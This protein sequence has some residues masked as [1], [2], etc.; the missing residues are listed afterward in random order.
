MPTKN[1]KSKFRFET[2]GAIA[3][4]ALVGLSSTADA[5]G[6][7]RGTQTATTPRATVTARAPKLNTKAFAPK[8]VSASL[9]SSLRGKKLMVTPAHKTSEYTK[10]MQNS[11]E[12]IYMPNF[13]STGHTLIRVGDRLFDHVGPARNQSFKEVMATVRSPAYGFVFSRTTGQVAQLKA[14]FEAMAN[15]GHG[16]SYTGSGPTTFSCAGFITHVLK[17]HAPELE[18]GLGI[19]A[20]GVAGRVLRSGTHD[21]VTLYG[22]AA[23]QA[24]DASFK[25]LK[26]Q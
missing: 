9:T 15:A 22:T 21:A 10:A 4:L 7:V 25:F 23:T 19:G 2:L 5:Q 20:I 14:E 18:I 11:V 3:L 17:K 13:G 1:Y 8:K 6:R 12:L 24:G 26:L 16:F